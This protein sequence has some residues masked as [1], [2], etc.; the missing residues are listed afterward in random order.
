[1]KAHLMFRNS[2]FDITPNPCFGWDTL[3]QDLGLQ[4]ILDAMSQRDEIIHSACLS[5]LSAPLQNCDAVRYRLSNMQDA[6]QN[7]ETVRELYAITLEAENKRIKS[8]CWISPDNSLERNFSNAVELL[9]LYLGLL[10]SLRSIADKNLRQF[11]SDGFR[12]LFQML[13]QELDDNYLSKVQAQLQELQ[14]SRGILIGAEPGSYL[15]GCRYVLLKNNTKSLHWSFSPSISVDP[16]DDTEITDLARR[17]ARAINETTNALAQSAEHLKSF[18]IMLRNELSFYTGCLNLADKLQ[19]LQLPICTADMQPSGCWSRSWQGLYDVALALCSKSTPEGNDLKV[20]NKRMYLITGANQGGKTTFL[21]SIGQAQLM[22]QCGMITGARQFCAPIRSNVL[23]HFRK[24]EDPSL[25]SGKLDEELCRMD[26]VADHLHRG[27]MILF[28]ESFASTNE[29]EGAEIC[30]QIA[31]AL[32][33][34]GVEIFHVTHFYSFA[35]EFS[36]DLQVESLQAQ[37]LDNGQ[38][39]FKILPG[40]PQ[41]TAYGE[42]LYREIFL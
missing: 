25:K 27:S 28:N 8:W 1:M 29:R 4:H 9:K 23:T 10:Q 26:L 19:Q 13:Q 38:R 22:A 32:M 18:F 14:A 33:E 2:D 30:R 35:S 5:A 40:K 31:R 3:S 39:T 21:R 41:K 7:P 24:E 12:N 6:L 42:D 34:N 20:Q 17:Q 16:H 15:Q 37:R 11:R 36:R